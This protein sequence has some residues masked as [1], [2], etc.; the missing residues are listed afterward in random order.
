M[1]RFGGIDKRPQS[2]LMIELP[3][4]VRSMNGR[5]DGPKAQ[6]YVLDKYVTFLFG[7]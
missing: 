3:L 4:M 7:K 1:F 6:V 5:D 2:R